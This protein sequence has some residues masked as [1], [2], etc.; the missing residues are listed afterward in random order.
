MSTEPAL[1]SRGFRPFFLLGAA[2]AAI[3]LPVWLAAYV[4]GYALPGGMP[5]MCFLL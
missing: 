2:W 4:H 5:A 1:W 3:A